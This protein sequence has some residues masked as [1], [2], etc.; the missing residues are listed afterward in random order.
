MEHL[1]LNLSP[2][3]FRVYDY[4]STYT[5]DDYFPN[6]PQTS[7]WRISPP[8]YDLTIDHSVSAGSTSE[9]SRFLQS[10][11]FFGLIYA[12][13]YDDGGNEKRTFDSS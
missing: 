7:G 9:L 12:V 1:G 3:D 6:F 8:K 11:L 13:V 2:D 5:K 4:G 10:W